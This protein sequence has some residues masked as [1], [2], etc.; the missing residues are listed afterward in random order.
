LATLVYNAAT[1]EARLPR[2]PM[3]VEPSAAEQ[4]IEKKKADKRTRDRDRKAL[5]E[6]SGATR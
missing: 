1:T 5:D 6:L 4:G 3:P 2:K